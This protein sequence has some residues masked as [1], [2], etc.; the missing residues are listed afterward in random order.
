MININNK[1]MQ[2]L[3]AIKQANGNPYIVGGFVRD[4]V[5]GYIPK[6]IDIECYDISVSRLTEVLSRFGEVNKIGSSFGI[7]KIDMRKNGGDEL[8]I[9][10]PRTE[11]K[12]GSGHKGF[13][14]D[15]ESNI[16]PREGCA[17]RDFT[18]NSIWK[19]K[20]LKLLFVLT[21]MQ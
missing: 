11:S 1:T 19:M 17:R 12:N 14:V 15:F 7:L 5:M 9:S 20:R 6:D 16:T 18:M 13:M 3:L 4:L 10:L 8:D 2:L 21:K